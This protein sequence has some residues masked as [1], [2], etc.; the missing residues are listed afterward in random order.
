MWENAL[1]SLHII[2]KKHVNACNKGKKQFGGIHTKARE[3]LHHLII[4]QKI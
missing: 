4:Q 2:Y 3:T 1:N